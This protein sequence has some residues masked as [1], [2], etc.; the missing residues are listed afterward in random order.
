MTHKKVVQY[1]TGPGQYIR[2]G[3]RAIVWPIDHYSE[4]VSNEKA[5]MTS[6]VLSYDAVTGNFETQ[7]TIYVLS[8]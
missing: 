1:K 6:V 7:N 4:L 3:Q 5:V 8:E 2:V